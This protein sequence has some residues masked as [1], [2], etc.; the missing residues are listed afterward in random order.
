[1]G[2]YNNHNDKVNIVK[3]LVVDDHD[4]VR[5][6]LSQVLKG[7]EKEIEVLE[8]AHCAA[9]FEV[10][11][12][13]KDL[14]LVLLDYQLPDVNGV[15]A[16]DGFGARYPELPIVI[17]SGTTNQSVM[18]QALNKGAAGFVSKNAS[19]KDLLQAL[20]HVLDGEVHVPPELLEGDYLP[21]EPQSDGAATPRQLTPRQ[22]QVL[23]L[24]LEGYSSRAISQKLFLS[25]ETTKTHVR[26][27]I[28]A[29][30]AKTRLQAVLASGRYGYVKPVRPT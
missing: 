6:G 22:E 16:L 25:E 24:L 15:D 29:F 10:A 23:Y 28:R 11:A 9:A 17:L 8:A 4:L 20:R 18:R 14:D 2:E 19:S 21:E 5:Q 13:H 1:M 30:G 27:I 7:L 3:I 26:S 12:Q